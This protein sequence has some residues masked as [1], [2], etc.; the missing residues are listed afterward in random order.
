MNADLGQG[1]AAARRTRLRIVL[2]LTWQ[3]LRNRYAGASLGLLWSFIQPL[4]MTAILWFVFAVALGAQPR[5]GVPFVAWFLVSLAAWN[6]FADGLGAVTQVFREYAFLVQKIRFDAA[7]LPW[8]KLLA[9]A[10]I[11]LLLLAVVLAVL[12]AYGV[13]AT[14]YWLQTAYYL[15]ALALLLRAGGLIAATLNVF[16]RDVG[17]AIQAALQFGFWMSPVFWD[18]DLIPARFQFLAPVLKLNPMAYVIRGYRHSLLEGVPFWIE[19]RQLLY[20]WALTA[21]LWWL[22][23]RLYR[24]LKP[25]FADV[26]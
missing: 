8:V 20:F 18:Y 1:R 25:Q 5:G 2:G 13:P 17:F 15:A 9:S 23:G 14:W 16:S 12:A 3:D 24:R 7:L 19:W 6:L 21:A 11:H 26:L 4:V 10:V 22:G